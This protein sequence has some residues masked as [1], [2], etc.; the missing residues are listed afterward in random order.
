MNKHDTDDG[1]RSQI[2]AEIA[3]ERCDR[4]HNDD[5]RTGANLGDDF[6]LKDAREN[7]NTANLHRPRHR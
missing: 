3:R 4:Q 5:T 7:D 2:E 1:P 6:R